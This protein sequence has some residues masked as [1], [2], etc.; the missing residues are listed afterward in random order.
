MVGASWSNPV[1][2]PID[3]VAAIDIAAPVL[4]GKP[5][6]IL[7]AGAVRLHARSRPRLHDHPLPP[8]AVLSAQAGA[9]HI[10]ADGAIPG[11]F[12]RKGFK[13]ARS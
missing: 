5:W 10:Q 13:Q 2:V 11:V 8:A 4:P 9:E 1:K 3:E 6:G 12:H 7:A